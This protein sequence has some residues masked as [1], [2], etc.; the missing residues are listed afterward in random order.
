M[1]S[2]VTGLITGGGRG[3]PDR[4]A[5]RPQATVAGPVGLSP[6]RFFANASGGR[7]SNLPSSLDPASRSTP[8][9]RP[10]RPSA[11]LNGPASPSSSVEEVVMI[12]MTPSVSEVPSR[13]G[14]RIAG[15]FARDDC[16]VSNPAGPSAAWPR[17]P[18]K[19]SACGPRVF[20]GDARRR[21]WGSCPS[22]C[23][24]CPRVRRPRLVRSVT[25]GRHEFVMRGR[26]A[27]RRRLPVACLTLHA[28]KLIPH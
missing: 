26:A 4:S 1:R 21:S 18:G 27:M 13:L 28:G 16:R 25:P 17:S 24:S 14:S 12:R 22:Q 20:L 7:S 3:R 2:P 11:R 9:R 23:C 5:R 8:P 6:L 15:F 10:P 19:L